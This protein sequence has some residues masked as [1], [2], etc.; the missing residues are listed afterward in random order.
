MNIL[1]TCGGT[2]GHINPALALADLFRTRHPDTK[3]LFAGA[4]GDGM[5]NTLVPQ[6]GYELRTLNVNSFRRKLNWAGL[7]HNCKA[8][9]NLSKSRRQAKKLLDEFRPDLVVG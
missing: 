3:I 1:F 5:E 7:K 9:C 4:V 8:V 6:A 2:A